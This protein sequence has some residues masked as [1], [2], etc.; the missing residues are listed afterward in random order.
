MRGPAGETNGPLYEYTLMPT[1]MDRMFAV[2]E[3]QTI[4]LQEPFAFTKGCRTMKIPSRGFQKQHDLTTQLYD[5]QADPAQDH[6]LDDPAVEQ[7]M[8]D[9]LVRLMRATDAPPEQ[10]TRLGL[11]Q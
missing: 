11:P 4:E 3:L 1:H 5:V 6:P 10:Y 7:R 9:H 2:D 8:V